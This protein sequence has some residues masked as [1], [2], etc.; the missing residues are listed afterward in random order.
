[1]FLRRDAH[2]YL[3]PM[4]STCLLEYHMLEGYIYVYVYKSICRY[5]CISNCLRHI[6]HRAWVGALRLRGR[7]LGS[8]GMLLEGFLETV[9]R[10]L[11][12][13]FGASFGPLGASWVP[14]GASW[15]PLGASWRPLGAEGSDFRFVFPSWASLGAVLGPSWAVLRA[16]WAVLAPSWAILGRSWGPLGPSWRGLGC[17]LGRL[18]VSGRRKGE[19][20]T[21]FQKPN[22]NY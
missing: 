10:P 5:M 18:G 11:G 15:G 12:S 3:L 2:R 9:L 6:R 22:G 13:R 8:R 14:L 19:N 7:S 1:M 21:N 20:A 16:S 4:I 17:L